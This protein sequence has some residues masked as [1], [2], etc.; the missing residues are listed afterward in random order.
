MDT[1][2]MNPEKRPS[3][4]QP[5]LEPIQETETTVSYMGVTLEKA[6][7]ADSRFVPPKEAYADYI[8]DRFALDLQKQIA[9]SFHQGDPLLIE[10]GTS[11]GKTTTVRKMAS[12]LGW[13]THYANLNGATDVEDLMG[14]YI[15]N[16][17]KHTED[18]PEYI[19]ADGKV[20]SGLRVEEGKKKIIILDEFNAAAPNIVIRLHEVLDAL[21]RG[22]NVVLAEDASET[23]PVDKNVT[24]V[25]ALMNP[26]GKGYFGREPLDPAQLRRWVY[27]KAP[28]DLPDDTFSYAVDSL[29][30]VAPE[31]Q[32]ASQPSFLESRDV[33]LLPEQLREIPGIGEILEKY[34]EFHRTAK[35]YVKERKV[36]ADQPQLFTYDDRMEPQRVMNFVASFYN[37]DI[38]E[39]MQQALEYYYTNKLESDIDRAQFEEIIRH[40]EYIP[41]Q[42]TSQR[43]PL[44]AGDT[45]YI[46]RSRERE[47]SASKEQAQR[48][49]GEDFLGP[50]A[51]E[52][53]FGIHLVSSEIQPIQF[54]MEELERA[55]DLSQMLIL[56]TDKDR[57]GRPLTI[58]NMQQTLQGIFDAER[59]GKVLYPTDWYKNEDFFKKEVPHPEWALVSKRVLPDSTSKNYLSQTQVI[60]DYL[61]NSVFAHR[62]I[63]ADYEAAFTEFER[64]KYD[65]SALMSSNWQE[66]ARM[67]SELKLNQLARRSPVEAVYDTLTYFQ[68]RDQRLLEDAYDWTM[69][70]RADGDL[71]Y[72]GLFGSEGLNV[73]ASRPGSSGPILGVCLSRNAIGL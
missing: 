13:E 39:T 17:H 45:P 54:S 36:A 28:T 64:K 56:R 67:L 9:V 16:P 52:K 51:V 8:N 73:Y 50:E 41:P 46:S 42:N 22:E 37:G 7:N 11:I 66:A 31:T 35:K 32:E 1:E 61:K 23:V 27:Y 40:I 33:A 25:V 62:P 44:E 2:S 30:G 4:E 69:S 47:G 15:P 58:Q 38:N 53:A 57:N 68:N 59:K 5:S 29:F 19:F 48:L 21:Q 24:K 12:E 26:P 63:P 60:A 34:K 71:V 20:T 65:I 6:Q 18:D 72:A 55:K 49:F 3:V 43:R 70:R 10:G 14:R